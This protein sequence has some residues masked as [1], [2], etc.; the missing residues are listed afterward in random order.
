MTTT[1]TPPRDLVGA[2]PRA[3]ISTPGGPIPPVTRGIPLTRVVAVELRKSFDTRAGFWLLCSIGLAALMTTAAIIAWAPREELTY[4]QFVLA[5]GM[6]MTVI[7]PVIA[8]LSVT[9][10]WTQRTGLATFTLVPH[11]GRVLLAKALGSVLV[12][13][14]STVVAF[15][16]AALGNLVA[17]GLTGRAPVWDADATSLVAFAAAITLLLLTGFTIGTLIRSSAG[18]IVAYMLY[19]FVAPGALTLL[20]MYQEWFRDLRPWIDAKLT[21]D[22]L[23]HGGLSGDQWAHLAVTSFVWLVVPLAVGARNVLRAEVK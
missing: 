19:A 11:R 7:L 22:A 15:V 4:S 8:A 23:M 21:Q 1:T 16:V 9:S 20:A 6:P 5:I 10:E 17:A 12:A 14:A 18:A 3:G 13:L 2:R